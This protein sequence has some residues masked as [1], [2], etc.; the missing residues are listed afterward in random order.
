MLIVSQNKVQIVR[1]FNDIH[2]VDTEYIE[3][4]EY[5]VNTIYATPVFEPEHRYILGEYGSLGRCQE[6]FREIVNAYKEGLPVFEM[7]RR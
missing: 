2:I 1:N 5:S 6:V 7:P 3:G 4:T